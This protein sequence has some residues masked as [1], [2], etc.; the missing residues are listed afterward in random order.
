M[1]HGAVDNPM[2]QHLA[3]RYPDA[4]L[5]S[6]TI[7]EVDREEYRKLQRLVAQDI[8]RDFQSEI[9]PVQYDDIMWRR[10]N[11]PNTGDHD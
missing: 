3:S 4:G 11:R 8:Q 7:E 9:L 6:K 2:M 10:L 1:L 5:K